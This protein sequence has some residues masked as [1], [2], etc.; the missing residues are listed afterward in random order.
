MPRLDPFFAEWS[1]RRPGQRRSLKRAAALMRE[2]ELDRHK[3]PVLGVVGS[4]GKGTAATYAAA[5]LAASGTGTVLVTGPSLR[6]YRERV[7]RDGSSITEQELA[8]LASALEEARRSLA[9]VSE[10]DGYLAPS[11]MFLIAGLLHARDTGAQVCVLEAGM[12][13]HRDE[14]RLIGPEVVALGKVFGEHL[15]V[16]GGTVPEI[17]REKARVAGAHTRN[18]VSLPQT[19][20]VEEAVG[21]A[22]TE[23]T[24]DVVRAE[25]VDPG[26]EGAWPPP[27]LRPPGLSA[28]SGVLG[29]AAAERMLGLMGRE[30]APADRLARVLGGVRLPAR[31]S[32]HAV[33]GHSGE[34]IVDS[35][36]N[37]EGVAAAL[38][39]ARELWGGVD[40]V[41]LCLPDH[42][43][44]DGAEAA[45]TGV[46]V[47]AVRLP[48]AHLRF[49]HALPDHWARTDA[50]RVTPE[51]V[52]ALG[53]RVLALGTVYFTGRALE[54][55]EA[56][57]DTLFEQG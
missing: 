54:A 32:R 13:G 21:S 46:P 14:L 17:A 40:H 28:A 57:T 48:E 53:E 18:L 3:V 4:K 10:F 29:V 16:L 6:S 43:D 11:G 45:L 5:A 12:G 8:G 22:L 42:K 39:H 31:L 36:I 50:D 19:P 49:D 26:S 51:T 34:I 44:V 56:A 25:T 30:S 47:T 2:L 41:L 9:P 35:A 27:D 38:A 23:A 55:V 24:G 33:P 7:R 37:G 52:S 20:E 15:G 1:A